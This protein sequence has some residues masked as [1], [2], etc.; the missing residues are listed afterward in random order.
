MAK[1]KFDKIDTKKI[2][3]CIFLVI[4]MVIQF[5]FLSYLF[6]A[7]MPESSKNKQD[8]V[9][10]YTSSGNLDYKVYLKQNEFIDKEYLDE[11]EA[12]IL[13]LIDHIKIT[14]LYNFSA[15]TKTKVTGTNKLVATLKVYYKESTDKN[16]NPEVMTKEKVLKEE[17][18]NFD[19]TKYSTLSGY[20]LYLDDYLKILKEFES[21]VKISVDGYIEVT[22]I[23]DFNGTV[24]GASYKDDY[25]T[26]LK[27]PL[28]DSVVKIEK[29][30]AKNK[31]SEV[32]EGDLVKTNKTVM[33]YIVVANIITF[34]I[35][36]LLLKKLF[37]FTNKS[38]YERNLSKILKN[39]DDIIVNTDT[40]IDIG[41]YKVI[42]ISEFK[43]ILNLSRELLLPIMNYEVS[44]NETWFYVIKDDILYRYIISKEKLELMEFNKNGKSKK[45]SKKNKKDNN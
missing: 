37:M 30:S 32:Y 20:D 42:E 45:E 28:S 36:C 31:T 13:D 17:L 2:I 23:N 7:I 15:T 12:Y 6:K 38:E 44:K 41:K 22:Q 1:L 11:G 18:M 9:M 8:V 3:I 27:I 24:G 35:I 34:I 16:N 14:S 10:S 43:E 29:Q 25:E 5:A 33:I 19:D 21:E 4:A 39:Y 40:L 26:V